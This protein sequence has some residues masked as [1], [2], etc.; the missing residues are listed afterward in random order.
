MGN[1]WEKENPKS[2]DSMGH[3]KYVGN[4]WEIIQ[5]GPPQLCLLVYKAHENFVISTTVHH[6]I[7]L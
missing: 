2:M 3:G 5:D 4:L 7:Q 1:R 6:K